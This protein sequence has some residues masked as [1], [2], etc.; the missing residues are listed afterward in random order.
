MK[1]EDQVT[2]LEL[3]KRLKELGVEQENYFAWYHVKSN[4]EWQIHDDNGSWMDFCDDWCSALTVAE[5]I[6]KFPDRCRLLRYGD[7][8]MVFKDMYQTNPFNGTPDVNPANACAKMLIYLIENK[9]VT[10]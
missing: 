8:W 5:L 10:P 3:S 4:G 2:N 7:E 6:V 1:I 9:L